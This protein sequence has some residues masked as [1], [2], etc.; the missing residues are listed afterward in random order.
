MTQFTIPL[1][2][3]TPSQLCISQ[4]K[5]TRVQEWFPTS[6]MN[7][8]QVKNFAGRLLIIDGHTRAAAAYL[9][10]LD[11]VPCTFDAD[12]WDWA[13]YAADIDLCAREGVTTVE[14]LSKR[15]VSGSDYKKL[16]IDRCDDLYDEQC[17]NTLKQKDEIIFFT[18]QTAPENTPAE[19]YVIL[20]I[21]LG[22]PEGEYYQLYSSGTPAA[23]GC[24]ERYS[25][26][27]WEAA[28]IKTFPPFRNKGCGRAI[29]AFL[30]NKIVTSGKTA[31]CR[32][33]PENIPMTK[34]IHS[35]GY[36]KLY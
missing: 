20:P 9:A 6:P 23:R 31:T 33:L 5:L 24:I 19:K 21:D 17:Y 25:Y 1:A 3:L 30:T 29:T 35:C 4:A 12:D 15:I 34:I 32:T 2:S 28:D 16:W 36:R 7:P 8:I 27:F 22:F 26:E 11:S 10:G 14:A 13:I 18:R